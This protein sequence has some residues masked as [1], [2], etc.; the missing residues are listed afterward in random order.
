MG[1]LELNSVFILAA[2]WFQ[3]INDNQQGEVQI[4]SFETLQNSNVS[5]P[6]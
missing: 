4:I 3:V 6:F 5:F 2:K 1:Y